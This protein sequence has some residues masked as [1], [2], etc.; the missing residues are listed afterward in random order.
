MNGRQDADYV[1][2]VS[3]DPLHALAPEPVEVIGL[4]RKRSRRRAIFFP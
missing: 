2:E 3:V 1:K 4:L